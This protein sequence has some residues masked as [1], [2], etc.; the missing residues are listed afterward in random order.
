MSTRKVFSDDSNKELSYK[1]DSRGD[2]TIEILM[3]DGTIA[4]ITLDKVDAILL[5]IELNKLRR[6]LSISE[7]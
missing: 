7:K 6:L 1:M 5:I 3:G 2:L 4:G